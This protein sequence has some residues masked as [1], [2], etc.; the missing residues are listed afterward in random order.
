[1][2]S[3]EL[4]SN[5][6]WPNQSLTLQTVTAHKVTRSEHRSR[7]CNGE[8]KPPPTLEQSTVRLPSN[9]STLSTAKAL[10]ESHSSRETGQ[11]TA[12]PIIL[13]AILLAVYCTQNN[14]HYKHLLATC[15]CSSSKLS[16]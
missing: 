13:V 12:N 3:R 11:R 6:S 5:P 4:L 7:S 8:G 9:L 2:S 14:N 1:M 10:S 15:I 16:C